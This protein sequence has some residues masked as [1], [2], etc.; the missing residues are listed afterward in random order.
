VTPQE[1]SNF[2][3]IVAMPDQ[4]VDGPNMAHFQP[5]K[6][7]IQNYT[8]TLYALFANRFDPVAKQAEI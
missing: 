4:A 3:V 2:V 6:E 8:A 1:F 5:F 7:P